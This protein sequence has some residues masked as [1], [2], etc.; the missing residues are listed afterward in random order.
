MKEQRF[1]VGDYVTIGNPPFVYSEEDYI[2]GFRGIIVEYDAYLEAYG[3][4]IVYIK[5]GDLDEVR[6]V[7]ERELIEYNNDLFP[8]Y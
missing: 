7:L 4:H 8:I 2:A 3:C 5:T 6:K 1:K